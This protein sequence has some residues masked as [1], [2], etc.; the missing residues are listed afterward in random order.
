MHLPGPHEHVYIIAVTMHG[1]SQSD[2]KV[3]SRPQTHLATVADTGAGG[4]YREVC[5]PFLLS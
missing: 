4:G 5:A 2:G 3:L 1:C